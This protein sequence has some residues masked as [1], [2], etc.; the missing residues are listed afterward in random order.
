LDDLRNIQGIIADMLQAAPEC[1]DSK[2]VRLKAQYGEYARMS[3]VM[4]NLQ[5][6]TDEEIADIGQAWVEMLLDFTVVL[7][8]YA[9]LIPGIVTQQLAQMIIDYKSNH[10][11]VGLAA[12]DQITRL[13]QTALAGWSA[14]CNT[15]DEVENLS[16]QFNHQSES[17]NKE[18]SGQ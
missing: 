14:F 6:P 3:E 5:D 2:S 16:A 4:K 17:T 18:A 13:C 12:V 7:R 8:D 10:P 9:D 11:P 1:A 15:M